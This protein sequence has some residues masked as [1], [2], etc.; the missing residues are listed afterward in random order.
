M[1]FEVAGDK[2]DRYMGRYS[3]ALAPRFVELAGI[4]AGPVLDVGCGPGALTAELAARLGAAAVA[5]VDPSEAFVA[6]CRARVPGAAVEVASGEALPFGDGAFAAALSQLV[7][8]FARD[9]D[10]FVAENRRVVRAG[11]VVASCMWEADGLGLVTPFWTAA[12][13]L[14]PAAPDESAMPFRRAGELRDVEVGALEVAATYADFDDYW[15]P[16]TFG[17]G[18]AGEYLVAQP[19]AR[20]DALRDACRA[21]LGDP[22]GGFTLT[23]RAIAVRGRA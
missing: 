6:A 14:D 22:P 1:T 9:P 2:Y 11:G 17:V 3:R 20:R 5:A 4:A 8:S 13:R 23:A 10:R 7:L 16:F 21:L 19:P 12:R 15:S 18:P